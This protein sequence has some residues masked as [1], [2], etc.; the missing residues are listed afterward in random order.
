M[1]ASYKH[2]HVQTVASTQWLI[3]HNL[4]TLSPVCDCHVTYEGAVHKILPLSVEVIDAMNIKVSW[5]VAR[6]GTCSIR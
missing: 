5:S 2:N 6:T 3:N 4:N 1:P